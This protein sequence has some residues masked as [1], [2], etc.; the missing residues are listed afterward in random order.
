M[1]HRNLVGLDPTGGVKSYPM[2]R[3]HSVRCVSARRSPDEGGFFNLRT[4]IAVFLCAL[5]GCSMVSATLLGFLSPQAGSKDSERTLSFA[6]R[7]TYQRAI[8]N[9]YW[10]HRIWPKERASPKP[11]LDSVMSQ[12]KLA[13]KVSDYLRKSQL[14]ED[15]WQHAITVEQLQAEMDRMAA[16]TKQPEVLRELFEALGNDPFVIAECLARPIAAERLLV[17][18][19]ADE[20]IGVEAKQSRLART[21]TKVSVAAAESRRLNYMLPV[22]ASPSAGCAED[23]WAPTSLTNAPSARGGHTAVWTGSEMIVWGGGGGIPF[24]Y[25]N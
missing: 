20:K 21:E 1:P 24:T 6:E 19:T 2:K 22:V 23:T 15:H 12:P 18:L 7:V 11:P 3:E 5:V 14:L 10:H 9:V 16:N 25:F 8:E 13:K 17:R 4:S